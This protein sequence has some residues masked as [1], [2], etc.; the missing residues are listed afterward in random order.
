MVMGAQVGYGSLAR[1]IGP[2]SAAYIWSL[3]VEGS[4]YWTYHTCFRV[5]GII[6]IIAVL[7]QMTVKF[8]YPHTVPKANPTT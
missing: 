1:I 5:A 3:T 8:T 4:G 6:F 2:L 7:L